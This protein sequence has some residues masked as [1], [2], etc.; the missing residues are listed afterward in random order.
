MG[1]IGHHDFPVD[2][3][4]A[5]YINVIR[6]YTRGRIDAMANDIDVRY[7]VAGDHL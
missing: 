4:K 5:L 1:E 3:R 7:D 6:R 2:E